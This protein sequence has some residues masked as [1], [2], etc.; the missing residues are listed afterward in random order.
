[1]SDFEND[2]VKI[3]DEDNIHQ[4]RLSID[5]HTI[6]RCDFVG[7]VYAKYHPLKNLGK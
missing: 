3:N 7:L 4:M 5:L 6:S 1:M 2:D